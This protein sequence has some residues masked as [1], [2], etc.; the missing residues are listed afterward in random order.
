MYGQEL[1][2]LINYSAE[3]YPPPDKTWTDERFKQRSCEIYIYSRILLE[4]MDT[5]STDPEDIL[6]SYELYYE[7]ASE[8]SGGK[9]MKKIFKTDLKVIKTLLNKLRRNRV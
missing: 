6:E 3:K 2:D 1:S 8:H 9:E 7:W 4:C 5:P